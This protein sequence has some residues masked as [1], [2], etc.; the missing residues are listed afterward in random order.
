MN[1]FSLVVI[2]PLLLIGTLPIIGCAHKSS[3][4]TPASLAIACDTLPQ[5]V[6]SFVRSV[7]EGDSSLFAS[8]VSY[9]LF[10]PYPLKDIKNP[11]EMLS[12]YHILVDDSLKHVVKNSGPA[13]WNEYGWRGW[14]LRGGEYVWIDASVY[15]I[16]YIS[17]S[18]KSMLDSLQRLEIATLSPKLRNNKWSPMHT[19]E[20][21]DGKSIYRI[22]KEIKRRG[23]ERYRLAQYHRGSKLSGDPYRIYMG[24]KEVEGSA[25]ADTY[26]FHAPDGTNIVFSPQSSDEMPPSIEFIQKGKSELINVKPIYW[27]DLFLTK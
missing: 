15:D 26:H 9:P 25:V 17:I 14:A 2:S 23:E 21:L 5:E 13:D 12:Y 11:K 7:V 27:L 20:S 4:K 3:A 22:D 10:R 16:P 24:T 6:R 19:F 8:I 1:Y 18:E